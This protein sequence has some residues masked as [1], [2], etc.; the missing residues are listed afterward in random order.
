MKSQHSRNFFKGDI[1]IAAYM[2]YVK[3]NKEIATYKEFR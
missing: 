1:E 3:G 2:N